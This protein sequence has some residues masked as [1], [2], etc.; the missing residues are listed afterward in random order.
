MKGEKK[1]L[2]DIVLNNI[3]NGVVTFEWTGSDFGRDCYLFQSKMF[4]KDFVAYVTKMTGEG[5]EE[6]FADILARAI[7]EKNIIITNDDFMLCKN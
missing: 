4:Q 1:S 3:K 6:I 7:V 2:R 5:I